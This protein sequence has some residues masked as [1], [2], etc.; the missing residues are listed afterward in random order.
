MMAELGY[1]QGGLWV[2]IT[3]AVDDGVLTK[4]LGDWAKKVREIGV[5]THTDEKPA[6]PPTQKEADDALLF[7]NML[8]QY[9]FVLPAKFPKSHKKKS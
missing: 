7:A 5:K 6:K 3:K 2:R 9:L 8:A 1:K 4:N